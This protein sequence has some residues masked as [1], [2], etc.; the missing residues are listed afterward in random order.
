MATAGSRSFLDF[1]HFLHCLLYSR[2]ASSCS[3]MREI[4]FS[5]FAQGRSKWFKQLAA[6]QKL[7]SLELRERH[8]GGS[9]VHLLVEFHLQK[10]LRLGLSLE[11]LP[12]ASFA[13]FRPC[14]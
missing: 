9:V 8:T 4:K 11:M 3:Q 7:R 13:D 2:R 12:I 1:Q 10:R 6:L 14:N 5:G